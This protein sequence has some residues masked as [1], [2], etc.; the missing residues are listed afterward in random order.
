MRTPTS[1]PRVAQFSCSLEAIVAVLGGKWKP[2]I[3][4]NLMHGPL[5]FAE[6]RRKLGVTEKVLTHQL[7]ELESHGVVARKVSSDVPPRVTYSLTR[8]GKTLSPILDRMGVWGERH[9]SR[10]NESSASSR[11]P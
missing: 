1:A 10:L 11:P 6:L 8:Y 5:R 4:F 2:G 9:L 3:L 7:R